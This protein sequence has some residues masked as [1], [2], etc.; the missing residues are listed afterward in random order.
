MPSGQAIFLINWA[1]LLNLGINQTFIHL[2]KQTY[3]SCFEFAIVKTTNGCGNVLA[4]HI[5][6][7]V[8]QVNVVVYWR[9]EE[10]PQ[11]SQIGAD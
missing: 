5:L 6:I 10:M 3:I 1:E 4:P 11:I 2:I 8:V 7:G 9:L